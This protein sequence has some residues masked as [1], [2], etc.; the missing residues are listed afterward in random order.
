MVC[1]VTQGPTITVP[2]GNDKT[3]EIRATNPDGSS[4]DMTGY[5]LVFTVSGGDPYLIQKTAVLD[6][7]TEPIKGTLTLTA[8]ELDHPVGKYEY[9]KTL[10]KDGLKQSSEIGIFEIA[11]VI[12][13]DAAP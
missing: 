13:T 12:N 5:T 4:K 7:P 1:T 6:T 10:F 8:E 11:E 2:Q 3:W 9:D